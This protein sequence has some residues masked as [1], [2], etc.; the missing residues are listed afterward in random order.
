MSDIKKVFIVHCWGGSSNSNWYPWIKVELEKR[1]FQVNILKMPDSDNPKI[2]KWVDF[3]ENTIKLED[4]NEDTY[5]IG[6]SIGCQAIMRYLSN[7]ELGASI[8]GILFV[9]GWFDLDNLETPEEKRVAKSWIQ[10]P[11]D[12][13][14]II[15]KTNNI[16]V[17]ISKDEPY[18]LVD[19]N[20]LLFKEKLKA[21]V[22]MTED[23]GHFVD[24]EM[25]VILDKFLEMVK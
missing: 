7:L 4:L 15:E 18:G 13:D 6:H 1:N 2:E 24:Q 20:S 17:L 22:F 3:L 5:F 10:T 23:Y 11:I 19:E 21:E 12:F 9:A 14:K 8:G 25:P 16:N